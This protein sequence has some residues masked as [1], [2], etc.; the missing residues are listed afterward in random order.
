MTLLRF[1]GFDPDDEEMRPTPIPTLVGLSDD[2]LLERAVRHPDIRAALITGAGEDE[3][4]EQ[5][6]LLVT[7]EMLREMTIAGE[8]HVVGVTTDGDPLFGVGPTANEPFVSA[9]TGRE[10]TR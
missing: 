8:A 9:S 6:R 3:L 2:Q 10:A 5:I 1:P 7:A 4:V